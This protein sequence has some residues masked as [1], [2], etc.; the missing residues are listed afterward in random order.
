MQMDLYRIAV[1]GLKVV[2]LCLALIGCNE[3]KPPETEVTISGQIMLGPVVGGHS[4]E[5]VLY[6][7]KMRELARPKVNS[8]GT[9]DAVIKGYDGIVIAKLIDTDASKSDYI[10]EATGQP[11]NLGD[12][13]LLGVIDIKSSAKD[14]KAKL[15]ITPLS[16]VAAVKAGIDIKGD[17]V[18]PLI[19]LS[20]KTV[21][22]SN[23]QVS[24]AF[25]LGDKSITEIQPKPII[26]A[27]DTYQE[28]NAFGHALAAISGLEALDNTGD[29]APLT[30]IIKELS[31]GVPKDYGVKG[32]DK[33]RQDKM[34]LG[35]N[36]V[37]AD[38]SPSAKKTLTKLDDYQKKFPE[39]RLFIS[40]KISALNV[41]LQ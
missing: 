37:T 19:G 25:G 28:G 18:I 24:R 38:R 26:S 14:K 6:T 41:F 22:S 13:V 7:S 27:V 16:T 31:L 10:D 15:N 1:S 30:K 21:A 2:I 23:I 34:V 17:L 35:I 36:K 12:N 32:L 33:N 5:L 20:K 39:F 11:K 9:Y 8:D 3:S 29:G 40:L 4:H